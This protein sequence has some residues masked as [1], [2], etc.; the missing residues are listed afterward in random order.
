MQVRRAEK[1]DQHEGKFRA[2]TAQAEKQKMHNPEWVLR[3]L[4]LK[5]PE[6]SAL[7]GEDPP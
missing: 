4:R 5:K 3:K 7:F 2:E 6:F 1:T